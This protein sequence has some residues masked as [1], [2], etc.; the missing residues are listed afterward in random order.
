[1]ILSLVGYTWL[2]LNL[3]RKPSPRGEERG[4]ERGLW[5]GTRDMGLRAWGFAWGMRL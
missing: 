5:L 1:M 3:Y 4:K 2:Y